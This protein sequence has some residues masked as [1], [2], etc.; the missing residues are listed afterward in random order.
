MTEVVSI[1]GGDT[2]LK[3]D[4]LEVLA[5]AAGAELVRGH[6]V[7]CLL[8][9]GARATDVHV[10]AEGGS[11]HPPVVYNLRTP[12]GHPIDV[13]QWNVYV[14]QPPRRVRR[15]LR[16]LIKTWQPDLILLSE[17]YRCRDQLSTLKGYRL[18]QGANVGEGADCAL[19]VH[20]DHRVTKS[21]TARMRKSWIGP[22]HHLP[23]AP[24][25]YPRDRI[26]LGLGLIVVR[27]VSLHLPTTDKA[28]RNLPA[29][30]EST[31]WI[32]RWFKKGHH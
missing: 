15:R 31:D 2:N 23:K 26:R 12:A 21:S 29:V 9:A 10:L 4:Q 18:N 28:G 8:V 19:L 27:A 25:E 14:G 22:K 24:R 13:L 30:S 11:D 7:D 17:A 20:L 16:S 1:A 5:E 6:G 32:T 3:G